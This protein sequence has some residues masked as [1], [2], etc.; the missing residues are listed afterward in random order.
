MITDEQLKIEGLKALTEA[1]G[2]VEAEKFIALIMRSPFDY[3]KWQRKLWDEKSIKEI[4]DAAM[5]LRD[6]KSA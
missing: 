5:K 6:S 2:D 4:S 3:T 1:L